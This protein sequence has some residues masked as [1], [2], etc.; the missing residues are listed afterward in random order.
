MSSS[1]SQTQTGVQTSDASTFNLTEVIKAILTYIREDGPTFDPIVETETGYIRLIDDA[2]VRPLRRRDATGIIPY[3]RGNVRAVNQSCGEVRRQVRQFNNLLRVVGAWSG[4][5]SDLIRLAGD[6]GRVFHDDKHYTAIPVGQKVETDPDSEE[7][8][9]A[10]KKEDLGDDI[11]ITFCHMGAPPQKAYERLDFPITKLAL[12]CEEFKSNS[13]V[14]GIKIE[15]HRESSTYVGNLEFLPWAT[16]TG[17]PDY[18]KHASMRRIVRVLENEPRIV[19]DWTFDARSTPARYVS[20]HETDWQIELGPVYTGFSEVF[21]VATSR[22][23]SIVFA[24]VVMKDQSTGIVVQPTMVVTVTD[25]VLRFVG[26]RKPN[27]DPLHYLAA[28]QN[29]LKM[30]DANTSF[31]INNRSPRTGLPTSLPDISVTFDGDKVSMIP[32][33]DRRTVFTFHDNDSVMRLR[34]D[35]FGVLNAR[36][37]LLIVQEWICLI[38]SDLGGIEFEAFVAFLHEIYQTNVPECPVYVESP[39]GRMLHVIDTMLPYDPD[40]YD[41]ALSMADTCG[42]GQIQLVD[43]LL[44]M[45]LAKHYTMPSGQIEVGGEVFHVGGLVTKKTSVL[46]FTTPMVVLRPS[47]DI[48]YSIGLPLTLGGAPATQIFI[49]GRTLTVLSLDI[50]SVDA[51]TS[52]WENDCFPCYEYDGERMKD[53]YGDEMQGITF[54]RNAQPIRG[55]YTLNANLEV[56]V[57]GDIYD[58][59]TDS[60]QGYGGASLGQNDTAYTMASGGTHARYDDMATKI[61]DGKK[62]KVVYTNDLIR[63]GHRNNRHLGRLEINEKQLYIHHSNKLKEKCNKSARYEAFWLINPTVCKTALV[64]V[65]PKDFKSQSCHVRFGNYIYNIKPM[66]CDLVR[67]VVKKY[68][69]HACVG[70][71]THIGFFLISWYDEKGKPGAVVTHSIKNR[72]SSATGLTRT[73][74]AK[75]SKRSRKLRDMGRTHYNVSRQAGVIYRRNL[76]WSNYYSGS[77]SGAVTVS[78]GMDSGNSLEAEDV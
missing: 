46:A 62:H 64:R 44:G 75:V 23:G 30:M 41:S 60:Y 53:L 22:A 38:C 19:G 68:P 20:S 9:Y 15:L 27:V 70:F 33:E 8:K 52:A 67:H 12:R 57:G 36:K 61:T 51:V 54:T 11:P 13:F 69:K 55:F 49:A 31:N 48:V 56:I 42:A 50:M 26:S 10:E 63:T 71:R 66:I 43:V 4:F 7:R 17:K 77:M 34:P 1:S 14:Q 18:S 5:G 40:S 2:F 16:A 73:V 78:D 32:S 35:C 39:D 76:F 21:A 74:R 59:L 45:I 65:D 29:G 6:S 24:G 37:S 58:K 25:A 72:S 28:D 3:M 47:F